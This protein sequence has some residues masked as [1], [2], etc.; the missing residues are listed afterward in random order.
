MPFEK[1]NTFGFRFQRGAFNPNAKLGP[2]GIRAI[3]WLKFE[4]RVPVAS[5]ADAANV[6]TVTIYNILGN[7]TWN[8]VKN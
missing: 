8:W 5:I 3:R 2:E 7:K 6:S 1:G 4:L